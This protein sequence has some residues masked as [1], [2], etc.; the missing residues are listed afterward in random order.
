MCVHATRVPDTCWVEENS[1]NGQII[2]YSMRCI[3]I[4]YYIAENNVSQYTVIVKADVY[5]KKKFRHKVSAVFL[6][7]C[8]NI[9]YMSEYSDTC[10]K[11]SS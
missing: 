3:A 2:E 11:I 6:D 5:S 4:H 7:T 1:S 9:I 10:D 8:L